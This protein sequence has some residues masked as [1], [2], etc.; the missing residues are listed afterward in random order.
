MRSALIRTDRYT[1][2]AMAL[3]WVIALLVVFNLWLG[4]AHDSLPPAWPV[5]PVHK[6][7]GLTVLAL[8]LV[9]IGWRL[10]HP[11]PPLPPTLP[12]WERIA[13]HATHFGFYIL[14]LA[15]PMTGWAMVSGAKRSPLTWFFQFDIPY[16]P[17]PPAAADSAHQAHEVLGLT[18]LALVVLH[19]AAALRHRFVLRDAVLARMIPGTTPRD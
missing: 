8:T 10:S 12:A 19:V 13:A 3:H 11:A 6:S 14:L 2:V 18:M 9:R 5:I 7:I 15:L 17:V 4:L 16:L 1:R